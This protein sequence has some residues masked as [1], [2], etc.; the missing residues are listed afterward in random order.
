[1]W[2]TEKMFNLS[3]VYVVLLMKQLHILFQNAQNYR[4]W[5]T[6]KRDMTMFPK[7]FIGS[8]V[9]NGDSIKLKNGIY[10]CQKKV[11]NL[12]TARSFGFDLPI[13]TDKTLQHNGSDITFTDKK[14]KKCLLI[15]PGWPFDTRIEETEEEKFKNYSELKYEMAKFWKMRKVEVLPVVI[16]ALGTVKKYFEKWIEKLGLDLTVEALQ[17]PCLLEMTRIIL[18]MK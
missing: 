18:D 15:D 14:S 13:Q 8:Y 11:Q 9:K 7:C 4:K 1:M 3:V 6:K 12:R 10:T 17:K 5:S 16:G 2:F